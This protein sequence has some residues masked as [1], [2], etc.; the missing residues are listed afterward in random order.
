M[1]LKLIVLI[2]SIVFTAPSQASI[3]STSIPALTGE[4]EYL[5]DSRTV[6]F[7][8]GVQFSSITSASI[9]FTAKGIDGLAQVCVSVFVCSTHQESPK[10]TYLFSS[11]NLTIESGTIAVDTTDWSTTRIILS[12]TDQFLDGKGTLYVDQALLLFH[13]RF[14][15]RPFLNIKDVS[16]VVDGVTVS[17]V[18]V[19]G[20]VWLFGS[21]LI[22]FIGMRKN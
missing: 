7:D 11:E 20:A 13:G 21:G 22:G 8:L 18:P 15:I 12:E 1:K 5:N 4:Y 2:M 19:P 3:I 16:M 6:S 14:Q 17:T 10:I 9:E